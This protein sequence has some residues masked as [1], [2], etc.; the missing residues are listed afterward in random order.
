M[1]SDKRAPG[2][3]KR[4]AHKLT[5]CAYVLVC[6]CAR[7]C[8]Y[9]ERPEDNGCVLGFLYETVSLTHPRLSITARLTGLSEVCLSTQHWGYKHMPPNLTFFNIVSK[10][11]SQVLMGANQA[12]S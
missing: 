2:Q 7:I 6:F 5:V 4:S 1:K 11:Q 12:L 10:D 3:N 9:V 8:D